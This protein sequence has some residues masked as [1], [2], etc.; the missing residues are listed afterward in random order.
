MSGIEWTAVGSIGTCVMGLLILVSLFFM[1][2]QNKNLSEQSKTLQQSVH[3]ATYQSLMQN[4]AAWHRL[5]VE[6]PELDQII[7]KEAKE[8]TLPR[9]RL[10]G[11]VWSFWLLWKTY[12]ISERSSDLLEMKRGHLGRVI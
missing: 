12:V 11:H 1:L 10:T 2:K 4:E 7:Y 5:I 8:K 6:N 9:Q 3:S